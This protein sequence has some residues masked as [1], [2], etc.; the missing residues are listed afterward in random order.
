M[1][2]T[3]FKQ[4]LTMTVKHQLRSLFSKSFLLY[5]VLSLSLIT[6]LQAQSANKLE[7]RIDSL[8]H[9][10]TVPEKLAQLY[11]NGFMTTPSNSRLHIPGFVMDDGPHGVRLHI[12]SAFP[13]GIAMAA[14]WDKDMLWTIGKAMGEE[15][16]AF[17]KNQQLG[18]C[19][20][21]CRDPRSGRNAESG[22]E[23]PYLSG[24][25]GVAV[26]K[27]IQTTPVI[28]TVKHFMVESKQAYRN[29]CNQIYTERWMMEHFGYNF[30]TSI[31]EGASMSIMS[32]YNLVNGIHATQ[33]DLLLHKI[34][35]TRWG[36]PFYVVSDWGAVH[37]SKQAV[38]AGNDVCMGSENYKDDLPA[39][40]SSGQLPI[41][42]I[43]D[44]VRNVLRTKILAG[45]LDYYPTGDKALINS[46]NHVKV[47][48][49]AARKSVILLKNQQ[50][51]LPL[52][53]NTIKK[54]AVIGP[55][56]DKGN[57]N[58]FGSSETT[59]PYSISVRKGLTN[60]L[61]S[62]KVLF[63]NGCDMN[64]TSTSG[65]EAAKTIAAQADVVVFVGGLDDTQEGEA[66]SYG[67]DRKNGVPDL[68]GKQQDLINQLALV[69]PNIIVVLQSGGVCSVHKCLSNI[70]GFLYS[71]YAGMEAGTAIADVLF[72]DY[73][74]AGRMPVTMPTGLSQ[75]PAWDDDFTNDFG[76]GY[77]W[78]DEKK[79][80]PEYAFGFGL[81]YTQFEY[82]NLKLSAKSFN[83]GA[84]VTLSVDVKNNGRLAGEEVVQLYISNKNTTVWMPKKELKGFER[85]SLVSGEKKM[86]TFTL[87]AED[88]YYWNSTNSKYEILPGAYACL[89][90]GSSDN[91]P[92]T[93]DFELVEATAKPDLKITQVFTMPRYPLKGEKVSFY[94]L[95]KNQGNASITSSTPFTIAYKIDADNVANA[96]N[97][98]VTLNPGEAMLIASNDTCW[99]AS[100]YGKSLL[101][102][103]IDVTNSIDESIETNNT[104]SRSMEVFVNQKTQNIALNKPVYVSSFENNDSNLDGSQ[105]VDGSLTTRWSSA[106]SDPQTVVIDL[107]K[108]IDIA[109]INLY[110][111]D[112]Y[113]KSY[114]L[115]VS[116]DSINWNVVVNN[117][118][119]KGGNETYTVTNKNQRYVRLICHARSTIYGNSLYEIEVIDAATPAVIVP[120]VAVATAEQQLILPS[121][122]VTLDGSASTNAVSY[123]WQQLDGPSIASFV[124]AT[125]AKATASNLVQGT[126][127][128][129]LTVGNN[130]TTSSEIISVQ[131]LP[132]KVIEAVTSSISTKQNTDVSI[133]PNPA[134][135]I[136]NVCFPE[137]KYHQ[138]SLCDY[139]GRTIL[140]KV[141]NGNSIITLSLTG[142]KSGFYLVSLNGNQGKAVCKLEIN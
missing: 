124:N 22:S 1:Y 77:R 40:V 21:L 29:D 24:Q 58:C 125:S 10:M 79:F 50:N 74:P 17:G 126:Y 72:G 93:S 87:T 121:N 64:S 83:A 94:A 113:A 100:D 90:G 65:Y 75:L 105:L 7:Q 25:I 117:T 131:V 31:Q 85:V 108:T 86:V 130:Q 15:F 140:N 37:D 49:D 54:I 112:A 129:K 80:T 26:I 11:N 34:L 81:S 67:N 119:G 107:Q 78:F 109:K 51:I 45:M 91:L 39:L 36:F 115:S 98:A 47:C 43:D 134:K 120:P 128:F 32:S 28:A 56:A 27:G 135:E 102:G 44:A 116:T 52:N 118:T 96:K 84:P 57:L 104:F 9:A 23:D 3:N 14:T 48:Q 114:E 55:N 30:R 99:T 6:R 95:V 69:N 38:M 73:N 138:L 41:N 141:I 53:K 127:T 106:F 71:F 133:Y 68:P 2:T 16:W 66:Y 62:A 63:A 101:S 5:C 122:T 139:T 13:T 19:I 60:K 4:H 110:W 111:E 136:A 33:S 61:G 20:D 103:N 59:P 132:V 18:P 8:L 12:A 142:L 82:S 89:V 70:K 88:F 137:N 76:C 42:Y 35:R 92:L 123:K 46:A 97:V